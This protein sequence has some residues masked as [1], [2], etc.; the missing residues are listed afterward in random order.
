M[1][2]AN[3]HTLEYFE[4]SAQNVAV[5]APFSFL[6]ELVWQRY[7]RRKQEVQEMVLG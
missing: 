2:F 4:T 6:A 5:E 1:A 3:Q 7:E